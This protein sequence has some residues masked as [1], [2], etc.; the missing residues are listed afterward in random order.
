VNDA[1]GLISLRSVAE[2]LA[3]V[4]VTVVGWVAWRRNLVRDKEHKQ[5]VDSVIAERTRAIR[6]E[7]EHAQEISRLKS[8]FVVTINHEIRTPMSGIM[9]ALELVLQTELSAEQLE[10]LQLSKTSADSVM[11]VLDDILEFSRT[12]LD[13]LEIRRVDFPLG[14]CLR[15]AV[16]M[17]ASR[18]RQK[19][20]TLR[21]EIAPDLPGRISGDPARLHQVLTK[22]V[23]NAVKFSS[24]GEV[25]VSVRREALALGASHPDDGSLWLLFCVQDNGI[26]IPRDKCDAIFEPLRQVDGAPTR[27]LDGVGSGL[28]ACKRLVRL[29][30]GRIWVE[31]DIRHGSRFY[32]TA[33]VQPAKPVSVD[34][35]TLT[36]L[37]QSGANTGTRPQVLLVEDNQVN[38]LVAVRLLEKRGYYCLVA[39]NGRE[40]LT[41]LAEAS[42]NLVLMDIQM[43][44]MDGYE[45]T[46]CIRELEKKTGA[47]VPIL[48]MTAH[49]TSADRD[50]CLLAGMDGHIAKPVQSD[51]LYAA[52]DALLVQSPT[53]A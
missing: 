8:Q 15:G 3:A 18:A 27:N 45:A 41:I 25:V 23:D 17:L 9:G 1:A 28:V 31:S 34:Q 26:G 39:N 16:F 29:L 19:H 36:A 42:V 50:A 46:R 24:D 44:E 32:F 48:A 4:L 22:I 37:P 2:L 14:H 43:P 53:H 7:K 33:S 38:Q 10:Y 40:A 12:E 51:R 47:R 5:K 6:A 52:I 49:A 35:S 30:G 13:K 11:A 20:L 21:I